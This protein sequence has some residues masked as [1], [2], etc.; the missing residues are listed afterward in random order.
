M[1]R[2]LI[3]YLQNKYRGYQA[4]ATCH[5]QNELLIS[6]EKAKTLIKSTMGLRSVKYDFEMSFEDF[7]K[8]IQTQIN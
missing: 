8:I 2:S 3:N 4:F 5:I 6:E 1:N 7:I